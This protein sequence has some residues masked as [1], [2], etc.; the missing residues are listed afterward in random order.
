MPN[1]FDKEKLKTILIDYY[2]RIRNKNVSKSTIPYER[3]IKLYDDTP[4]T[5]KPR[6]LPYA[7]QRE[8]FKQLDEL[9]E[10]GIIEHSDRPYSSPITPVE[11]RDCSIRLCCGFWK[12]NAKTIPKSFPIPKAENILDNMYE[13]DV[14]TV[15]DLKSTYWHIPIN[16]VDKH[17]TAFV[18]PR[19]SRP[20]VFCKNGV[21][22][23]FAKFTGKHLYQSLFFNKVAGQLQ[24]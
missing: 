22:R 2:D 1:G 23:N 16:E 18:I 13:A 10:K 24:A 17:K 21:L 14:F 9:L 3:T 20:E 7:Y 12:L 4:V 15:L 19:S 6:T 8:I 11:K 5:S